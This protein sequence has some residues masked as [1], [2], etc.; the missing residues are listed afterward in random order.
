MTADRPPPRAAQAV[1]QG[2]LPQRVVLALDDA[3]GSETLL[4]VGCRLAAG[5][6]ARLTGLHVHDSLLLDLARAGAGRELGAFSGGPRKLERRELQLAMELQAGSLQQRLV[7]AAEKAGVPWS[8]R[9]VRG[10]VHQEL[11]AACGARDLLILGRGRRGRRLGGSARRLV[12]E[13]QGPVLVVGARS[14]AR[15]RTVVAPRSAQD[16]EPLVLAAAQ[17][18]E[19]LGTVLEVLLPAGS[20]ELELRLRELLARPRLTV[21]LRA[22]PEPDLDALIAALADEAADL[23]VVA[24]GRSPAGPDAHP[25]ADADRR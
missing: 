10:R 6:G 14:G 21:R 2:D 24:L 3:T 20:E 11:R 16:A 8:F 19:R 12:T 1:A 15:A 22:Q 9:V 4:A 18:A 23:V 13:G 17:V 7:E 25:G 5:L